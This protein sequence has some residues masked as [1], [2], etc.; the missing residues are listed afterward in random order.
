LA[1]LEFGVSIVPEGRN[2]KK[3]GDSLEGLLSQKRKRAKLNLTNSH[4]ERDWG[5]DGIFN[6]AVPGLVIDCTAIHHATKM[7]FISILRF[8]PSW[9]SQAHLA[10]IN[11]LKKE[12]VRFCVDELEARKMIF[13]AQS[14]SENGKYKKNFYH[15]NMNVEEWDLK[16]ESKAFIP[17]SQKIKT[18]KKIQK[19]KD[20][21]AKDNADNGSDG[22]P[23][24]TQDTVPMGACPTVPTGARSTVPMGAHNIYNQY[25]KLNIMGVEAPAPL[26]GPASPSLSDMI[27]VLEDADV[28]QNQKKF[29]VQESRFTILEEG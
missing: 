24:P 11:D 5:A 8:N 10:E 16:T 17:I 29:S 7:I 22:G 14:K 6:F 4:Q 3:F 25:S 20:K 23:S 28:L 15:I 13:I 2:V 12:K 9:P 21:K 27:Q 18:A 26:D 19:M 1:H